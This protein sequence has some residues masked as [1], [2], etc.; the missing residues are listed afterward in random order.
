MKQVYKSIKLA[1]CAHRAY[2]ARLK[3][4]RANKQV[5]NAQARLKALKLESQTESARVQDVVNQLASPK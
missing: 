3:V 1:R 2:K 4:E 5:K